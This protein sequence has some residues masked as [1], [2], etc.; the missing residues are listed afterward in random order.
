LVPFMQ[1]PITADE[2]KAVRKRLK[3]PQPVFA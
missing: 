2:V 3:L 1:H